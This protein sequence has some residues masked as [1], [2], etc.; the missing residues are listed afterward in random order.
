MA[1]MIDAH[2]RPEF[3]ERR[4]VGKPIEGPGHGPAV[5]QQDRRAGAGT[6]VPMDERRAPRRENE[7]RARR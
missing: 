3:A 6:G 2:D 1:T 4:E 5:Q 7:R